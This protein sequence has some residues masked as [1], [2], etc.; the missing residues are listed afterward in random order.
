MHGFWHR[1]AVVTETSF[2]TPE[3]EPGVHYFEDELAKLPDLLSWLLNSK[4]GSKQ[5]EKVSTNAFNKLRSSQDMAQILR[6]VFQIPKTSP[7]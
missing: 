1:T 4:D 5:L 3:Y 2:R 7:E 6:D